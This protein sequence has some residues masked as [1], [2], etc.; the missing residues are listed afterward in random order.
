MGVLS[1]MNGNKLRRTKRDVLS[2]IIV[3]NH[4]SMLMTGWSQSDFGCY[5]LLRSR[6]TWL[7]GEERCKKAGGHLTDVTSEKHLQWLS[8]LVRR[9]PVW[10]G[11]LVVGNCEYKFLK[12]K[13][14]MTRDDTYH[15]LHLYVLRKEAHN[16]VSENAGAVADH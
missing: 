8:K 13:F 6:L 16:F 1:D 4:V 9:R 11:K 15:T 5:K 2:K 14:Q 10:L 3:S 7:D 12:L